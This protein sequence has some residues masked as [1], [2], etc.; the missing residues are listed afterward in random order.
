MVTYYFGGVALELAESRGFHNDIAET[1]EGLGE[2]TAAVF[3][4][5]AVV[6]V[7]V[8]NARR[9]HRLALARERGIAPVW[10]TPAVTQAGAVP[11][12]ANRLSNALYDCVAGG[13]TR[14]DIVV[15]TARPGGISAARRTR[16]TRASDS[17]VL[18]AVPKDP[19]STFTTL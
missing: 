15:P 7:D 13:M 16:R 12:F 3:L 6:R 9:D 17:H 19:W 5:W 18:R 10:S 1:H 8:L 11:A 4:I 14:V 2:L